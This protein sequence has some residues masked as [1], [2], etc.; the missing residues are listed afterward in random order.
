MS[1]KESK[2]LRNNGAFEV[3]NSGKVTKSSTPPDA[4]KELLKNKSK[5]WKYQLD[6]ANATEGF[7]ALINNR[8]PKN[9]ISQ[10]F[11]KEACLYCHK[12]LK[13]GNTSRFCNKRCLQ[14]HAQH[15][16]IQ[17]ESNDGN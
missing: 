1:E 10:F 3:D 8:K 4:E 5:S 15:G 13:P 7:N 16:P 2:P 11:D 14:N 9:V 6:V 17:K 12:T